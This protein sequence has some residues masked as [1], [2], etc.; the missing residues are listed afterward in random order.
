MGFVGPGLAW[1]WPVLTLIGV[2]V[3]VWGLV[4]LRSSSLHGRAE[5]ERDRSRDLLRLRYA[6]GE[7]TEDELQNG[8]RNLDG[9]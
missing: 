1:A 2:A 9:P 7:I 6:Q 8:L 4:L 3:L 5:R